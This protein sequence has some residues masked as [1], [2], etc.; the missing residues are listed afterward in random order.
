MKRYILQVTAAITS[1]GLDIMAARQ[2]LY[3]RNSNRSEQDLRKI[4]A[5]FA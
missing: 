1:S 2:N 4:M 3:A 5:C